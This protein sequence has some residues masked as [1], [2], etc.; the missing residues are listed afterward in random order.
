[1]ARKAQSR[2]AGTE[3]KPAPIGAGEVSHLAD[4]SRLTISAVEEAK[5][6]DDLNEVIGYFTILDSANTEGLKPT[7]QTVGTGRLRDDVPIPFE[8]GKLDEEVPRRKGRF[9]RAPRVF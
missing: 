7:L 8:A 2:K 6:L 4:L 3:A 1:M 9:V 5:I